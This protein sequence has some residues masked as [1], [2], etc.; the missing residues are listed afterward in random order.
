[1]FALCISNFAVCLVLNRLVQRGLYS[2]APEDLH[3][4]TSNNISST[5]FITGV[6]RCGFRW[7][8]PKVARDDAETESAKGLLSGLMA[9]YSGWGRRGGGGGA[10]T[11]L[12]RMK[13]TLLFRGLTKTKGAL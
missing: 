5:Y 6:T 1:M 3:L 13:D 8:V 11:I 7:T 10:Q 4:D 9:S 2:P 12:L